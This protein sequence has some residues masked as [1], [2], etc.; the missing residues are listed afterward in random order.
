MIMMMLMIRGVALAGGEVAVAV[1]GP[2]LLAVSRDDIIINV[3]RV[4]S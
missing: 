2:D 3:T 1:R 4:N